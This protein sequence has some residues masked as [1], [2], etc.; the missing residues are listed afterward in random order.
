MIKKEE[1]Q[2][3]AKL[4]R[5]GL[6]SQEIEKYRKELSSI[7]DFVEKLKRVDV[8]EVEATSHP[9]S[10]ENIIREDNVLKF[11]KKLIDGHL[12][13]KSIIESRKAG[14]KRRRG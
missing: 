7:L 1:V 9:L 3:I 12:K 8:T 14:R 6:S 11:K 4:A 2:H 5:L 13:V 10:A